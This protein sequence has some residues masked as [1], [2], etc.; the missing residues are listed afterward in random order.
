MRWLIN[1]HG[2]GFSQKQTATFLQLFYGSSRP[3]ASLWPSGKTSAST[4]SDP[5]SNP[6]FPCRAIPVTTLVATLLGA[7][8]Y[9][10]CCCGKCMQVWELS[11]SKRK[12]SCSSGTLEST[13]SFFVS[14]ENFPAGLA[15]WSRQPL[16]LSPKKSCLQ[17]WALEVD[18]L[19]LCLQ[20]KSVD[21]FG[22]HRQGHNYS[23]VAA[24]SGVYPPR[25]RLV[26]EIFLSGIE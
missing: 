8:R 13:A 18:R 9:R 14:K 3:C 7:W 16:S 4:A 20:E 19:L 11:V 5:F 24:A 17:A 15:A 25:S 21:D 6:A 22:Q 26:E 12:P 1:S 10:V 23:I 2:H